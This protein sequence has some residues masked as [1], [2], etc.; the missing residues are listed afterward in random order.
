[1]RRAGSAE[2]SQGNQ[3]SSTHGIG[4]LTFDASRRHRPPELNVFVGAHPDRRRLRGARLAADGQLL[5]VQH[6]AERHLDL[7]HRAAVDHHPAGLDRRH[8]RHRRHPGDHLGRHRPEL[9]LGRRRHRDD[10][11]ELRPGFGR[12]RPAQPED[13]AARGLAGPAGDRAGDR[14]PRLRP[15]RGP[16]QRLA[17]R[18]HQDPAV[19]R[20]PRHDGDRPRLR[21]LV[22]EG[23][24]DQLP[25]RELCRDRQGDD[26]GLHLPRAGDPLPPDP[27][28]HRLRQAHLRHRLERG[29]GADVRDQGRPPQGD[30]LRHRRHCS[31]RSP[32]SCSRRRT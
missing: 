19:H 11:H 20:H 10:R 6:P 5:P 7:Q 3:R 22:V 16:D 2:T 29:G 1:M 26:A 30:G 18:L 9:G 28:L 24:A 31:P 32:R 13:D 17:D 14:R 25:D 12:Q 8:H 27:A 4:G 15:G 21:Q 23:R